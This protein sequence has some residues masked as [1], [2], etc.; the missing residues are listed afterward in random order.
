MHGYLEFSDPPEH[1]TYPLTF[2][3]KEWP[4]RNDPSFIGIFFSKCRIGKIYPTDYDQRSPGV[5]FRYVLFVSIIIFNYYELLKL[6]NLLTRCFL[7]CKFDHTF[8][9][10]LEHF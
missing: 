4:R 3:I 8:F 5:Y 9:H 1:Y 7:K 10:H 6:F 2:P